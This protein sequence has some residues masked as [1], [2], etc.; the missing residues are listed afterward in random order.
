MRCEDVKDITDVMSLM[1]TMMP[2]CFG[3][4]LSKMP[5]EKRS[6]YL[7][8]MIKSMLEAGSEGMSEEE[9]DYFIAE[10]IAQIT[11]VH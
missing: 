9:K 6:F 5:A 11:P 7:T 2:H 4:V 10:I 1:S 3:L 8:G